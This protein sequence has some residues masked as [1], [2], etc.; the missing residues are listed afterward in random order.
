MAR[1]ACGSGAWGFRL[2]LGARVELLK[3]D[4]PVEVF[5]RY[6]PV[7][8]TCERSAA[9]HEDCTLGTSAYWLQ[10]P[11]DQDFSSTC[12]N[13]MYQQETDLLGTLAEVVE[14]RGVVGQLLTLLPPSL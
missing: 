12:F 10:L 13:F 1:L 5:R 9:W 8:R 14:R 11:E 2:A 6:C 7:G 4:N 3:V